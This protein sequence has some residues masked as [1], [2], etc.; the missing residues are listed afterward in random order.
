MGGGAGG[1]GGS[2]WRW[3][4]VG[5]GGLKWARWMELGESGWRPS[6]HCC[7]YGLILLFHTQMD[8][9]CFS[10]VQKYYALYFLINMTY[11]KKSN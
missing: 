6:A 1:G 5:G 8:I 10:R 3:G 9:Y 7:L 2:G 11:A 4:T